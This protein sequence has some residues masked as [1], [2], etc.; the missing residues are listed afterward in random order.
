LKAEY[1][2]LFAGY[3]AAGLKIK[4]V[5]MFPEYLKLYNKSV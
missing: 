2:G 1:Y 5:L 4:T 3:E